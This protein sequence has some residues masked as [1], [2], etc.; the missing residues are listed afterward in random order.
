MKLARLLAVAVLLGLT[1][2]AMA[3]TAPQTAPA[4]PAPAAAAKPAAT[5]APATKDQ[6]STKSDLLDLNSASADD[7]K[8]LPGIGD[9]Y[10]A[11]IIAGRPYKM[12]TQL[13]SKKILP[14][15]TYDG[16]KDKVIARQ[17]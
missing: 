8:A 3:Q 15:K 9:A 10:S 16:I 7:L 2:P 17:Q 13:V 12:K 4:K 1:A 14:Q 5:P 6:G 11:K